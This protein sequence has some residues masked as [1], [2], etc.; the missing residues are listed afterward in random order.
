MLWR[1]L[2]HE[3][4]NARDATLMLAVIA[5]FAAW[6]ITEILEGHFWLKAA[7]TDK[8]PS[9]FLS[10]IQKPEANLKMD[11]PNSEPQRT[12]DILQGWEVS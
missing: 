10:P 1:R 5:G 9:L 11:C 4:S 7:A 12:Y 2:R 3:L 6:T 8:W